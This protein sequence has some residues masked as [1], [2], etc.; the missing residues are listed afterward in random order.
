MTSHGYEYFGVL[1]R[2]AAHLRQ[3]LWDDLRKED[4][5]ASIHR[6]AGVGDV[7]RWRWVVSVGVVGRGGFGG[8]AKRSSCGFGCRRSSLVGSRRALSGWSA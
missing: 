6:L 1:V 5:L 8:A 3:Q 7:G 2:S 4:D